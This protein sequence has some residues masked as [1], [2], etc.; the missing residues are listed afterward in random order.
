MAGFGDYRTALEVRD[1]IQTMV[2]AEV[3]K[4]RPRHQMGTVTSIDRVTRRCG[5]QFPGEVLSTQVAMGSIQPSAVGQVVR[6]EGVQ[7]DRYI[8]DVMG[9]TYTSP[10]EGDWWQQ[11]AWSMRA[12]GGSGLTGGGVRTVTTSGIAW[13]A[14]FISI[15]TGRNTRIPAG[16]F[17]MDMPPDGTSVPGVGGAATR[18]VASGLIPLGN[19]E[20]LYYIPPYGA[21]Q[22]SVPANFRVSGFISDV[23][24]PEEWI[25]LAIRNGDDRIVYWADGTSQDYWRAPTLL[26]GWV[27]YG[28]GPWDLAGYKKDNGIVY[29]TGLIKSGA[30]G[31]PICVLPV[32][33]RIK[34]DNIFSGTSNLITSGAATAGTAHTHGI[35]APA[36]R[37]DVYADG[38]IYLTNANAATG[39]IS[40]AQISYPAGG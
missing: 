35:A 38:T 29:L 6:V 24:I 28:I 32:G 34:A 13:D 15:S 27:N 40:L 33:Y 39:Y 21:A 25:L 30:S 16:H 3:E 36:V 11:V 17:I 14:R 19:W 26:N 31:D 22:T 9:P 8:A 1:I 5:V 2:N 10:F 37:L 4:I 20:A 12:A 18:S 7:G 23:D